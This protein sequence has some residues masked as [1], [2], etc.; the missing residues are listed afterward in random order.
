MYVEESLITAVYTDVGNH[1][2]LVLVM[3]VMEY[4]FH[5]LKHWNEYTNLIFLRR[6]SQVLESTQY[7]IYLHSSQCF[8]VSNWQFTEL[9]IFDY[10][11]Y[12]ML[13]LLIKWESIENDQKRILGY[14]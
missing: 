11:S 9:Y 4:V 2:Q 1:T 13:V 7:Y 12:G 3:Y 6:K 8:C 14:C 5:I 10:S